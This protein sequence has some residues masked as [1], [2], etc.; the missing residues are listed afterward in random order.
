MARCTVSAFRSGRRAPVWAQA[1]DGIGLQGLAIPE[2][3]GGAGGTAVELGVAFEEM[4]AALYCGP[5]FATVGLAATALLEL[6][7]DAASA[8]YTGGPPRPR[9][10]SDL[11]PMAAS[12]PFRIGPASPGVMASAAATP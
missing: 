10:S 3:L 4:G 1:A 5:F 2:R 7:D 12:S 8:D 6:A 11:I 9:S